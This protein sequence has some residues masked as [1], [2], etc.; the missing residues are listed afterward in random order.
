MKKLV[1]VITFSLV[2]FIAYS[3]T[4]D[5]T[6]RFADIFTD[7]MVLQ[8]GKDLNC[9]GLAKPETKV[10]VLL[11]QS[12]DEVLTFAGEEALTRSEATAKKGS[13]PNPG[14][15]KV[16]VAYLEDQPAEFKSV[17]KTVTSD[18]DGLWE[19]KLGKQLATFTPTYLAVKSGDETVAIKNL[20]IGEVWVASGQSNMS[21]GNSRDKMWERKGL[22]FNGLRYVDV[23]GDSYVPRESLSTNG[24]I[25]C[26]DGSVDNVSSVAYLFGQYLHRRLK[27]PVGIIKISMGGSFAREWC[28][29]ELLE[30]MDSPTVNEN[31]KKHDEKVKNEP[32]KRDSRG[33]CSLFNARFYPFRKLD[34]AGVIYLQGENEAL[35]GNLPQYWKTFPGVIESYRTAMKNPDLPFGIITLQ[36]MGDSS[37]M[38]TSSYSIARE[39]HQE[40]HK[41]TP[42]TGYIVAHDIGGGIHPNWK[43]PLAERAV[44]WALRDVYKVI[45][46]AKKTQIK[47]VSFAD[48]KA[49][50]EFETLE[51][52]DGKWG[53]PKPVIPRT[54]NQDYMGGFMIAGA[55]KKW[56]PGRIGSQQRPTMG[57]V[58]SHPM[59]KEPV[60]L[61][62]A[63][64]GWARAY[65]G[66]SHDPVPPY[67]TDDWPIT[68]KD[69]VIETESGKMS[70]AEK[71]Y[72][73][74]NAKKNRKYDLPMQIAVAESPV[75][76]AKRHVKPKDVLLSTLST[77][78]K[79]VENFDVEKYNK[80]APE[81]RIQALHKI[82]VRYWRRDRYSP[83]RRAK[84]GWFIERVLRFETFPKD[85]E[86]TLNK[87]EVKEKLKEL[88]K[89]LA[90]LKAELQKQPD[91]EEMDFDTMLDKILV[92]M[93]NEKER[94]TKEGIDMQK[95]KG[96]LNNNPF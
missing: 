5:K 19:V 73:A 66:E 65:L 18:K 60:A 76:L 53:N 40:V 82:P 62:Y 80:L 10:E 81:L 3:A 12:K 74:G 88:Q 89:A 43:R 56:F 2:C 54:H 29:R 59:V 36:G 72:Y 48:G 83:A 64:D 16:R 68:E 37:G 7:N 58:I 15:G 24:W 90:N 41:K 61:R 78:E 67:R 34:V 21:W 50:V 42:N 87:P 57:L 52:K 71:R 51:L 70:P 4:A 95:H 33:P 85:M 22:I 8:R 38:G 96:E 1:A 31:I 92:V 35:C 49:L 11:T 39:I 32:A 25:V 94:L 28:S 63:W 86:Q 69:E 45:N 44:Y 77:M 26:E 13:A 93:D 55:D 9:W 75:V 6:L 17:T 79:L 27:V 20:L 14:I 30:K 47:K 23:S 46:G 84:W 91:A